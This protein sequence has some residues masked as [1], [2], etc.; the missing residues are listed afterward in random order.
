[1]RG[2][3]VIPAAAGLL[4]AGLLAGL[5][6]GAPFH[7]APGPSSPQASQAALR[8]PES[9]ADIADDAERSAAIFTEMSRVLTHPRCVNCHPSGDRPLQGEDGRPHEPA[10]ARGRNGF[11][12]P[13]M[14]CS[15]CHSSE[16]IAL[17][18]VAPDFSVPG[19]P[20]WHL[21]PAEMAWEGLSVAEICAQM[22][23][24]E[25]NGGMS[26]DEIVEHLAADSL[27]GWGW[28]PGAGRQPPPGNQQQLES[29]ARAWAETGAACPPAGIA[30]EPSI[31]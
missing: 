28:Q 15:T 2:L 16:N 5:A 30:G 4:A 10:A 13:G 24:P 29:L 3:A 20:S 21:A 19:S 6:L 1:M 31:R 9:F 11:G 14:R 23:D 17:P 7:E 27:V 12:P 18:G 25:R 8:S 26:L 22:T